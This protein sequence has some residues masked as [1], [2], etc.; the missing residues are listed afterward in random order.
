MIDVAREI[1]GGAGVLFLY[2][3]YFGDKMNFDLA[4]EMLEEEDQITVKTV[5]VADDVASAPRENWQSR[6]GVAG[7]FFAY[8][9]AG[10]CAEAMAPLE[11]VQQMAEKTVANLAT[12]GVA[13]SSCTIPASGKPTF[14]I[15][16]DEM[17][18]GMGIH[19]EPGI[20]RSKLKTS[21][22]ISEEI[23]HYL[24]ED[25][26]L[27]PDDEVAVLINGSGSTPL[28]EL[29]IVNRDVH[30]LLSERKI[31]IYKT[32]VGEYA[33][34]MDMAGCSVTLLK[35]DEELKKYLDAPAESPFFKQFGEA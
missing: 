14:T 35:L 24:I 33:T 6:R 11:K 4:A 15:E 1:H 28:E 9:I 2:G 12:M 31:N 8:K 7:I 34:S 23:T 17:E 18:I 25:L 5:R 16:E 13:L 10:A 20:K 3:H 26:A 29:Y 32:Y 30:L 22:E 19:G 21:K 27:K